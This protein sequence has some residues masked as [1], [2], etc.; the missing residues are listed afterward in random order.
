MVAAL[1]TREL[2]EPANRKRVQRVMRQHP[3]LQRSRNNDRRR[4]PG[5][6]RV[7]RPDHL[8]QLDMTKVWTAAHGWVYL[9]VTVD[10]CTRELSCWRVGLRTRS[11]EAIA[12]IEPGILGRAV[13]PVGRLTLG[14]DNGSQFTSRDFRRHLSARG[15][16]DR[17]GGY[18]DPESDR[19]RTVQET[20][21]LARRMGSYR[22]GEEGDRRRHPPN[23]LRDRLPH[24]TE[25]AAIWRQTD[26]DNGVHVTGHDRRPS[27]SPLS[28]RTQAASRVRASRVCDCVPVRTFRNGLN[29]GRA[30]ATLLHST[31]ASS[32]PGSLIGDPR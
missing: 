16:T 19:V 1:A 29:G 25:V 3:L 17:R 23:P 2:G 31:G 21:R 18:R 30:L 7:T 22:P 11:Q 20:L 15:V 12:C 14:S 9:H 13:P 5:F 28:E 32:A 4:R 10:C 6:Y 8:W 24:P 27:R 26:S